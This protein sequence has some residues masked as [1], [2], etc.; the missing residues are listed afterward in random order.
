[1]SQIFD[2]LQRAE[3]ERSGS[4]GKTPLVA[5]EILARAERL[6]T[7]EWEREDSQV[8]VRKT[9]PAR[10]NQVATLHA[11]VAAIAATAA[12]Q[13]AAAGR[14]PEAQLPEAQIERALA[15]V[16]EVA[17]NL[18]EDSRLVCVAS[19]NSPTAEAFRLLGVRI[20]DL[21][22]QGLRQDRPLK[23]ILVTSTLPQEGKS[24]VA[25][26][27]A[28]TLAQTGKER[29]LLLEGDV[30]KPSQSRLFGFGPLK[31][32]CDWLQGDAELI[33]CLHLL[34]TTGLWILPAGM[35]LRKP[36]DLLQLGRVNA[37]LEELDGWFDTIVIDSPPILPLA[38][39][40][41]WTRLADGILLVT[42]EGV[43]QKRQLRKGLESLEKDKLI[44]A[45]LNC[46]QQNQNHY[47]YY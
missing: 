6:A 31:G 11:A 23:R 12:A 33:Q 20:R 9:A 30:R 37:L 29:V 19:Q 28:C 41:L 14:L 16:N 1:M 24:T 46:A 27:L 43:T 39:T 3:A 15:S 40:S 5:T 25:A 4:N 17:L 26:N 38:D 21:R 36:L 18:S 47:Y 7:T 42:R 35:A 13:P 32:M 34:R 10:N 44:G 45:L 2:A 22:Q 8:E